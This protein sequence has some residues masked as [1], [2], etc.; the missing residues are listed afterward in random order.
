M[1]AAPK[2]SPSVGNTGSDTLIAALGDVHQALSLLPAAPVLAARAA[3][4]VTPPPLLPAA[5]AAATSSEAVA[6][7]AAWALALFAPATTSSSSSSTSS[8]SEPFFPLFDVEAR[9]LQVRLLETLGEAAQQLKAAGNAQAGATIRNFAEAAELYSAAERLCQ[10][11]ASRVAHDVLAAVPASSASSSSP[12][13]AAAMSKA[14]LHIVARLRADLIDGNSSS[15]NNNNN[16]AS[17]S[18]GSAGG[19]ALL[20]VVLSNRAQ[21]YLNLNRFSDARHDCD[22][23]LA[24]DPSNHKGMQA[25]LTH[26]HIH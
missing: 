2:I 16:T 8:C 10:T 26:T 4:T 13:A 5:A 15:N 24:K 22:A 12:A 7:A 1:V 18:A 9:A 25:T 23:V 11:F 20:P 19:G 21:M 17:G 3:L 6:T 14:A